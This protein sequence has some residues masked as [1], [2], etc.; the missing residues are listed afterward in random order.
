V[1]SDNGSSDKDVR[2][3]SSGVVAAAPA[4]NRKALAP[5]MNASHDIG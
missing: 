1:M 3:S 4:T 2:I 5:V